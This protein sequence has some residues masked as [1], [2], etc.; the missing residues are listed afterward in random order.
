MIELPRHECR[1]VLQEGRVS[2]I[3]QIDGDEPCLTF[4]SCAVLGGGFLFRT[5]GVP[6]GAPV[7]TIPPQRVTGRVS[8]SG[9]SATTRP[10]R[11]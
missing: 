6:E 8:G 2:H 7:V 3:A 1:A 9:P 10:G 4:M 5:G 11:L